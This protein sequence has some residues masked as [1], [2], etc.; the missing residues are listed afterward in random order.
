MRFKVQRDR[1]FDDRNSDLQTSLD[2]HVHYIF[3]TMA[4]TATPESGKAVK[5]PESWTEE[6]LKLLRNEKVNELND[7]QKLA[8]A[9]LRQAAADELKQA[10][11]YPDVVGDIAMLRYLIAYDVSGP[12]Q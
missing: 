8:I 9:G 10:P 7:V 3:V 11:D 12:P 4:S 5:L 1:S 6:Q 2:V